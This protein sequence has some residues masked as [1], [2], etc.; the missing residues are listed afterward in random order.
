MFN[1]FRET[2]FIL[3]LLIA[4][5]LNLVSCF[6][7]FDGD[8]VA[9]KI[10]ISG[11]VT[12]VNGDPNAVFGITIEAR[13]PNT[14]KRLGESTTTGALGVYQLKVLSKGQTRLIELFFTTPSPTSGIFSEF[15]II[16][17]NSE[18]FLDVMLESPSQVIIDDVDGG[19]Y[20][21]DQKR[22]SI[23]GSKRFIFSGTEF[24]ITTPQQ[25]DFTID[26][27]SKECIN[28]KENSTLVIN[29]LNF[30][31]SNCKIGISA[32][33][34]AIITIGAVESFEVF[35]KNSGVR[36]KKSSI[37]TLNSGEI[38]TINSSNAFGIQAEGQSSVIVD[39]MV[40]PVECGIFG[41]NGDINQ[42]S[43]NAIV[44]VPVGCLSP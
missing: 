5:S 6:D 22:I 40:P 28:A 20:Q 34:K 23:G 44:S 2:T 37:T 13:D 41:A 42:E 14:G 32:N 19:G 9:K 17:K 7:F 30:T 8:G 15:F 4:L 39:I 31:A 35:S 43:S 3:I 27:R 36:S 26:G 1:L 38:F 33:N 10:R 29:A 25:A 16:T 24:A 21:V 18:V 11:M 12:S